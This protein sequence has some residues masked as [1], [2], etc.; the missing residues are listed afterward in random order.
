MAQYARER[1]LHELLAVVHPKHSRFYARFL[2]FQP[3]G[4]LVSCS[5]V[6][7][8]PGVAVCLNFEE[9]DRHPPSCYRHFF[10]QKIP[11]EE[12]APQPIPADQLEIFA[13]LAQRLAPGPLWGDCAAER[14]LAT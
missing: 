5:H 14:Q 4:G 9:I 1:G 2:G 12:L 8:R 6:Q 7:N 13:P 3:A 10:G 11:S